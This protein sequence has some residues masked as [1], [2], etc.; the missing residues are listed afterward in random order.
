MQNLRPKIKSRADSERYE[1]SMKVVCAGRASGRIY[2]GVGRGRM[3]AI[4]VAETTERPNVFRP[5]LRFPVL[6]YYPLPFLPPLPLSFLRELLLVNP[7]STPFI[8]SIYS[9]IYHYDKYHGLW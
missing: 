2:A 6:F 4:L 7:A 9:N 1:S 8:S 5:L 3:T